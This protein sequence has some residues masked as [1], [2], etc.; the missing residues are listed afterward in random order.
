MPP[1]FV[2]LANWFSNFWLLSTSTMRVSENDWE[3]LHVFP[4][5]AMGTSQWNRNRIHVPCGMVLEVKGDL[6]H[7]VCSQDV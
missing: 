3:A 1:A 6:L 2:L 4:G 5:V 7:R